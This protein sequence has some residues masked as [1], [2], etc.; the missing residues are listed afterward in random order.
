[1]EW[2]RGYR[3]GDELLFQTDSED[4]DICICVHPA[5][6]GGLSSFASAPGIFEKLSISEPNVISILFRGFRYHLRR[7]EAPGEPPVAPFRIPVFA[8]TDGH[9][10][11]VYLRDQIK[12]A[13]T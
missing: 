13:A 6:D 2:E 7:E 4:A 10:G 8:L 11:C 9:L 5:H 12:L 1:M 3:S